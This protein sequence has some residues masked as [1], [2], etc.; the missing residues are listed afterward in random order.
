M[1]STRNNLQSLEAHRNHLAQLK[2]SAEEE[3]SS[4]RASLSKLE[5]QSL[6]AATTI[7]LLQRWVEKSPTDLDDDVTPPASPSRS[8]EAKPRS[9]GRRASLSV[10]PTRLRRF[11]AHSP[12]EDVDG[13]EPS[14]S[15]ER[16]VHRLQSPAGVLFSQTPAS[17]DWPTSA[18]G[19]PIPPSSRA[20]SPV[21]GYG[22]SQGSIQATIDRVSMVWTSL[23]SQ[24][25]RSQAR[26]QS[27]S[28]SLRR[29]QQTLLDVENKLTVEAERVAELESRLARRTDELQ[30]LREDYA[31]LK[32]RYAREKDDNEATQQ[33]LKAENNRLHDELQDQL[34]RLKAES[35]ASRDMSQHMQVEVERLVK[36]V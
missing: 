12:G 29:L 4:T 18:V 14:E 27:Q 26:I 15:P 11:R 7:K 2:Q 1:N 24:A 3:L 28:A 20:L 6:E 10:S 19:S 32:E 13:S 35:F 8:A 22:E 17:L 23:L 36:E 9:P 31:E 5:R 34:E 30:R 16:S 33:Q 25:E 21:P